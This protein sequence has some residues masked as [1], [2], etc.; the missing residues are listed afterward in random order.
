MNPCWKIM[1][2]EEYRRL[3]DECERAA[4]A[5]SDPLTKRTYEQLTHDW[6]VLADDVERY[7]LARATFEY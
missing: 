4:A 1:T 6:R 3:A 2:P 5:T 7:G